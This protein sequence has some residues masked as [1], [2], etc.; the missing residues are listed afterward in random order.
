MPIV[1]ILGRQMKKKGFSGNDLADEIG[2]SPVNLSRIKTGEIKAIRFSTLDPLCK[3][4]ECQPNDIMVF[5]TDEELQELLSK[6]LSSEQ[7]EEL[8]YEVA[9][10]KSTCEQ[11]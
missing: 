1:L 6:N 7:F 5:L 2:L 9:H 10:K 8:A 11:S 4:L 3:L